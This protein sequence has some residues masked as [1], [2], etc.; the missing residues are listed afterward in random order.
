MSH[1]E[2]LIVEFYDWR[3]YLVKRNVKVGKR[4]AGGWEMELD[5]VAY[6]PH[7]RH[8]IHIEASLDAHSWD[9]REQRYVKKFHSGE[10]FILTDVF[11][12]LEKDTPIERLAI[13]PSVPPFRKNFAGANA[14]SIDAFMADLQAAIIRQGLVSRCAIPEQYPLL[15]TLQ[16]ALNGYLRIGTPSS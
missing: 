5:V 14:V 6:H 3:G 1:L 9:R 8:L 12:W 2:S 10:K 16:L 13:F 15:R 7:T 4:S 11:T